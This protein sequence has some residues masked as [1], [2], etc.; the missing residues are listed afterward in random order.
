VEFDEQG[1]PML[2][3]A[4]LYNFSQQFIDDFLPTTVELGRSFVS[5][6]YQSTLFGRKGIFALDNLWD[7]LGA[8]TVIDPEIEYFFGKVTMY[9]TYNKEARNMI[10]YF[11]N[12]YFADPLKLVT[13]ID[14]LVTGTNGEEMQQ[15]FQGK[16]FK[17]DYKILNK[18]VRALGYNIPPLINAYMS[19]SPTMR[20]FGTAINDEFGEVEESGILIRI[21]QILE[22]K[23]ARHI[24]SYMKSKPSKRFL[25]RLKGIITSKTAKRKIAIPQKKSK[26]GKNKPGNQISKSKE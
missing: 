22:E 16:N 9:G 5:L 12:K 21:D 15:L 8:L 25:I 2:A 26:Q 11:L 18:E 14:P 20:F 1:K 4:H 23:R 10:L 13:P 6:E 24:D 7:G 17:E 19:L 3:T